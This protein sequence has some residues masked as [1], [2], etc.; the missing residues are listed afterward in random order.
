MGGLK[1]APPPQK[2]TSSG[3]SRGG[4]LD[5]IQGHSGV[6]GL[7]KVEVK[8]REPAPAAETN[9]MAAALSRALS[10]RRGAIEDNEDSSDSDGW[11]DDD[12]DW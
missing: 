10:G 3:G 1:K 2:K 7:R 4:L 11:D 5:A 12:S 9:A 8:E 6:G